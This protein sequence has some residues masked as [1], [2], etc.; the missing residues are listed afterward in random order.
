MLSRGGWSRVDLRQ[1]L[2]LPGCQM[3]GRL[4]WAI[5]LSGQMSLGTK[6]MKTTFFV[7]SFFMNYAHRLLLRAVEQNWKSRPDLS[8][9]WNLFFYLC[10]LSTRSAFILLHDALWLSI[11][12]VPSGKSSTWATGGG[13]RRRGTERRGGETTNFFPTNFFVDQNFLI[14][15]VQSITMLKGKRE[16]R[17]KTA[18]SPGPTF[19]RKLNFFSEK[20]WNFWPHLWQQ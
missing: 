5:Y 9:R 15:R 8:L 7:L 11:R 1:S 19:S 12:D 17:G 14:K 4:H 3:L 18:R 16:R 6:C 13:K 2:S 20:V 10:H